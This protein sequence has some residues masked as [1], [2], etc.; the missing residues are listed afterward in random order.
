WREIRAAE[1]RRAGVPGF[2]LWHAP[3]GTGKINVIARQRANLTPAPLRPLFGRP[4]LGPS[5]EP[6]LASDLAMEAGLLAVDRSA[7]S[8]KSQK[9]RCQ[10]R[11][12]EFQARRTPI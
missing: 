1:A 2:L 3:F 4:A 7:A 6:C 9:A 10:G 5:W 8:S 11:A 12:T